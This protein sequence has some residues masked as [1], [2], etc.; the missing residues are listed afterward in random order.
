MEPLF[1]A[2]ICG[3][4]AGFFREALHEVYIPR[5]QRGNVSFAANV[6]GAR[7]A[8][9]SALVH[10]FEHGRWGSHMEM[11][12]EGQGL[13]SEDQLFILMQAALYLTA[14]R[15]MAAPEVRICYECAESLCHLLNRPLLLYV[16]LMGQWR[17]C[18]TTGKVGSGLKIAQ[19]V[20]SLA[21]EQNEPALMIG[22]CCASALAHYFSGNFEISGQYAIRGIQIWRSRGVQSPVEEVDVPGLTCLCFEALLKWHVGE[23]AASKVTIEEAISLEKELNDIHG[24]TSTLYYAAIICY[25]ERNPAEV[26]RLASD[27]IEL[28]THHH[29]VHWLA[30]GSILR[31]W[32]R[33]V[34]GDTVEGISWIEDGIRDYR[35]T[36]AMLS[37]PFLAALKAEALHV[38]D[39]TSDALETITEAEA[40]IERLE[41]RYWSAELHRL[42]GV[43]LA[44]LGADEMQIEASFC[45][46][47]KIAQQ[48]KS[49]SLEKRAKAT[50]AEYQRQKETDSGAREFKLPLC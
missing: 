28:S 42:R 2:V 18:N 11:G 3:C 25:F 1:S 45:T 24:L 34:F 9:L 15:G 19:R 14:N 6:L 26:E 39:R 50:Y 7:G 36:G 20:Y 17:H 10:F 44:A 27:V 43:F 31:G 35:A 21:Q 37:L 4:N 12:A 40:L 13:T 47:I 5:I 16:A 33:S 32:A 49:A 23:M 8:L 22:A 46:A 48:Q 29:F 30:L 38:A 41:N